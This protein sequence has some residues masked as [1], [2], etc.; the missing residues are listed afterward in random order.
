MS[1]A[2]I[3][4]SGPR[5]GFASIGSATA[6]ANSF[7]LPAAAPPAFLAGQKSRP[8]PLSAALRPFGCGPI[9]PGLV[10]PIKAAM[11][12]AAMNLNGEH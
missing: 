6:P 9:A 8:S 3:E 10:D 4:G 7:P 2:L 11:G 5:T 12:A 1:R